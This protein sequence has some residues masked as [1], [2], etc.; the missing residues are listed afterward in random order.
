MLCK[1]GFSLLYFQT[2][3]YEICLSVRS[4][5]NLTK[6]ERLFNYYRFVQSSSYIIE[7]TWVHFHLNIFNR[8]KTVATFLRYV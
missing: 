5:L 7:V 3:W 8:F 4:S 2:S 6:Y 1:S